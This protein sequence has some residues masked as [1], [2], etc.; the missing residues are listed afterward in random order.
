MA[1]NLARGGFDVVGFDAA[2]T[3]ERLPPGVRAAAG[4]PTC[5]QRPTPSCSACPTAPR[6]SRSS[7]R[8]SPAAPRQVTTVIDLSTVG[9][10]VAVSAA[11]RFAA[12]GVT[13][14]DG[15]VSGGVGGAR[16]ATISLMFAGPDEVFEAH[17]AAL[18]AFA[19]NVFRVG[20]GPGRDKS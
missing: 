3:T 16:A 13:Y 17:R 18:E 19:G 11:T 7:T 5:G 15:P 2:G 14:V 4:R 9:P 6:C 20:S 8:S 1:A 10:T 12:V